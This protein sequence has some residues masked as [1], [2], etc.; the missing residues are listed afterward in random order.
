MTNLKRVKS[1]AL[2]LV[3]CLLLMGLSSVGFAQRR[4]HRRNP[5]AGKAKA[6]KRIGIGTGAGAVAGALLGGKRG[7]LIGGGVGA[8][9]GTAYHVHK[10]NQWNRRHRRY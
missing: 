10:K 6:A 3:A 1:I 5:Q 4:H 8:A 9:A 7:A 2:I